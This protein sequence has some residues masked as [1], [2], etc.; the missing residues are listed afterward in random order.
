MNES[1]QM[2][3]DP[4]THNRLLQNTRVPTKSSSG[5]DSLRRFLEFDGKILRC[6]HRLGNPI[7]ALGF[8][9][10]I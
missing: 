7:S 8:L 10:G 4:Y 5:Y 3:V 6:I 1:E 9:N 2:P